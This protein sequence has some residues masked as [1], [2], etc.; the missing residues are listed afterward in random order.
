MNT[1]TSTDTN[2][3]IIVHRPHSADH[4]DIPQPE[5][6][7]QVSAALVLITSNKFFHSLQCL[8]RHHIHYFQYFHMFF[9]GFNGFNEITFIHRS[10]KCSCN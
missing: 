8:Q 5:N 1:N 2:T 9:K 6:P 7:L 10:E 4:P 3:K